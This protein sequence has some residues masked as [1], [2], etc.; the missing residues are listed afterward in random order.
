MLYTLCRVPAFKRECL[1]VGEQGGGQGTEE[2]SAHTERH[3]LGLVVVQ[4]VEE[5]HQGHR[6]LLEPVGRRLLLPS[7]ALRRESFVYR[8]FLNETKANVATKKIKPF[9]NVKSTK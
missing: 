1:P 2:V 3:K 4:E 7:L 6:V 5:L 8:S 9:Q